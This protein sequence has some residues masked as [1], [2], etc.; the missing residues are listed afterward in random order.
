MVALVEPDRSP[1]SASPAAQRKSVGASMAKFFYPIVP[2]P[3][4]A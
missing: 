1:G 4:A 2:A 3:K